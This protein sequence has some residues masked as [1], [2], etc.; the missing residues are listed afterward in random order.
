VPRVRHACLR[1][2]HHAG[3]V[4]VCATMVH[5]SRGLPPPRF[6]WFLAFKALFHQSGPLWLATL[7]GTLVVRLTLW[8]ARPPAPGAAFVPATP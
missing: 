1:H 6:D 2:H 3:G 4:H 7:M 5:A 8:P